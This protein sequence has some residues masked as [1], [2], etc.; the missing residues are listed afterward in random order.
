[1]GRFKELDSELLYNADPAEIN[2]DFFV[3]EKK[4][5]LELYLARKI[6]MLEELQRRLQE[7]ENNKAG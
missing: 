3:S 7:N 5:D 4:Y 1:M 2:L 6:K